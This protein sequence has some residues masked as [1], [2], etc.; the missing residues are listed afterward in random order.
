MANA[1][2]PPAPFGKN[3]QICN[4]SPARRAP[5]R[6]CLLPCR[7]TGLC[8]TL[9]HNICP[10]GGSAQ[11]SGSRAITQRVEKLSDFFPSEFSVWRPFF[12]GALSSSSTCYAVPQ[13]ER[14]R[15]RHFCDPKGSLF[16]HAPLVGKTYA[17]NRRDLSAHLR[18]GNVTAWAQVA[19]AWVQ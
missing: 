4:E 3:E 10:Q 15:Y 6:R 17:R 8:Y 1:G 14:N 9:M 12:F 19:G 16:T 7:F 13:F 5:G 11:P 18:H 2:R